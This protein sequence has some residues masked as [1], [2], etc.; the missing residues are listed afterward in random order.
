MASLPHDPDTP[1]AGEDART[2][3]PRFV[4]WLGFLLVGV[5]VNLLFLW[6]IRGGMADP[7]VAAWTK[8]LSWLPFN[9]I[10]TMFYLVCYAKVLSW[11]FRLLALAMIVLNWLAFFA[12]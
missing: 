3:R 6:G 4:N 5:L 1:E 10:A 7:G 8:A 12:A 9:L 2:E 11:L